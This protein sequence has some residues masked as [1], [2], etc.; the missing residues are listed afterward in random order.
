MAKISPRLLARKLAEAL[1]GSIDRDLAFLQ[2]RDGFLAIATSETAAHDI[3]TLAES[4]DGLT[5]LGISR[6]GSTFC[7]LHRGDA[8]LDSVIALFEDRTHVHGAYTPVDY[9]D[10]DEPTLKKFAAAMGV[11]D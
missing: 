6:N 1:R 9:R 5:E 11:L 8:D 2:F 4:Y 7:V 10:G 3:L